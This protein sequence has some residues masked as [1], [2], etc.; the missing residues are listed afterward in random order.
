MSLLKIVSEKRST[1][2][3]EF[4][5]ECNCHLTEVL[6]GKAVILIRNETGS[7]SNYRQLN[8]RYCW[9]ISLSLLIFPSN[10]LCLVI[11]RRP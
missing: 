3:C 6:N 10:G 4:Y 5:P 7:H 8:L 9:I 11:I 2:R 1:A